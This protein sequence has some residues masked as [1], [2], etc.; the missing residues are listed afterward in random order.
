MACLDTDILVGLFRGDRKALEKIADLERAETLSTTPIN[1]MELFK[2][3]YRS[4]FWQDNVEQVQKLLNNLKL[5]EFNIESSKLAG[6]LI[7]KLRQ[8]GKGVGDMDSI[9]AGLVIAHAEKLVTRN[10]RHFKRVPG[11]KVEKW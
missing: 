9:I 6:Q 10:I 1:A 5:L 4:K 8:E 11:L 7:E 2:G 3:A